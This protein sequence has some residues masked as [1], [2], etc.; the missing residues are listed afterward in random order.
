M[1]ARARAFDENGK[2]MHPTFWNPHGGS[3]LERIMSSVTPLYLPLGVAPVQIASNAQS[4]IAIV[5]LLVLAIFFVVIIASRAAPKNQFSGKEGLDRF[6]S[7]WKVN[8]FKTFAWIG[9]ILSVALAIA[10]AFQSALLS[11]TAAG[12]NAAFMANIVVSILLIILLVPCVAGFDVNTAGH[13][14]S[15]VALVVAILYLIIAAA[16]YGASVAASP[17]SAIAVK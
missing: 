10:F 3:A 7:Q 15:I 14:V 6:S 16:V 17:L 9:L 1:G 11:L 2:R 12:Q 8:K 5:L 13:A 4:V